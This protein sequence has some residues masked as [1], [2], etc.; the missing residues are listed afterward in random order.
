M[1]RS[2]RCFYKVYRSK[3]REKQFG[4]C[5]INCAQECDRYRRR[6]GFRVPINKQC[7]RGVK[8]SPSNGDSQPLSLRDQIFKQATDCTWTLQSS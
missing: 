2:V 5:I 6:A 8:N 1:L 3:R 7:K 4:A